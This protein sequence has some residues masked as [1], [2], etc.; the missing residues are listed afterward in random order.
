MN[1]LVHQNLSSN[2]FQTNTK[3]IK[4]INPN[5]AKRGMKGYL[6]SSKKAEMPFWL[7][8]LLWILIGAAVILIIIMAQKGFLFSFLE[9]LG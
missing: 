4:Y 1:F 2:L 8:M 6:F 9:W 5:R 7:I 3:T